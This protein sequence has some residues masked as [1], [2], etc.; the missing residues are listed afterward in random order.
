M[1]MKVSSWGLAAIVAVALPLAATP[2]FAQTQRLAGTIVSVD[3][4]TVTIKTKKGDNA[5][6]TLAD[7][8]SVL[9]VEKVKMDG[10][11]QGEFVGAGTMPQADGTQKAV[12][13]NIF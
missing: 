1:S 12:R 5:K 11:K 7:K 4:H 13:I 10:I 9:A 2:A 3:G 6:V 8:G